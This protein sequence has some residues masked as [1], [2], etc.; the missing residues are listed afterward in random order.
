MDLGSFIKMRREA[1]DM[2]QETLAQKAG[3]SIMTIWK[4]ENGKVKSPS[5]DTISKIS[6]VLSMNMDSLIK[7]DKTRRSV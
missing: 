6:S 2:T 3:V 4:I 5:F 7:N 1:S